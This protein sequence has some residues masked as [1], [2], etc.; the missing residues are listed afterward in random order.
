[1]TNKWQY[2]LYLPFVRII[3]YDDEDLEETPVP[4]VAGGHFHTELSSVHSMGFAH[5]ST[6]E[7]RDGAS[8]SRNGTWKILKRCQLRQ[9]QA[10]QR[11]FV[12][13]FAQDHG[14]QFR[15]RWAKPHRRHASSE[16]RSGQCYQEQVGQF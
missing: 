12:G 2:I 5:A 10:G 15:L 9:L 1:V 7:D 8:T 16:L 13:Q 6:I 4:P 14:G 11:Y 3:A